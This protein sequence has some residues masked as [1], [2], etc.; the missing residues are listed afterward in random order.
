LE[1]TATTMSLLQEL[2]IPNGV[3]IEIKA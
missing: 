2:S 1:P 3:W